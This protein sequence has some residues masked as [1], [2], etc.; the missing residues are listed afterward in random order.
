MV[1]EMTKLRKLLTEQ[2]IEWHDASTPPDYPL[3]IDRTHFD[4][5][6]YSWSV[7]N[8][9]GTYGGIGIFRDK[10]NMGLLELISNAINDGEPI[11]Y[12][13]AAQ[14]M[15]YVLQQE[16]AKMKH[17]VLDENMTFIWSSNNERKMRHEPMFRRLTGS[18]H[19]RM[20]RT[21]LKQGKLRNKRHKFT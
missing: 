19:R 10:K 2:G 3:Q 7:I 13:T 16:Y 6:G 15:D 18:R 5:K 20:K 8:G 4:Y 17:L 21:Q 9:F 1:E 14:V 11:G 12:L